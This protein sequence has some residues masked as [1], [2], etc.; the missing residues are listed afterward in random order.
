MFFFFFSWRLITLQYCSVFLNVA[1]VWG[2]QQLDFFLHVEVW[3]RC[4]ILLPLGI[5]QSTQQSFL[6]TY[7]N[8]HMW[9]QSTSLFSPFNLSLIVA[10][11]FLFYLVTSTACITSLYVSLFIFPLRVVSSRIWF[12]FFVLDQVVWPCLTSSCWCRCHQVQCYF[13]S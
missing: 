5:F 10:K 11:D 12:C 3:I 9:I 7:L 1:L 13:S 8:L 4:Q 2:E 6:W